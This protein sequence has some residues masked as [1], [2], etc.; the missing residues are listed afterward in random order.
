MGIPVA[1]LSQSQNYIVFIN[2]SIIAQFYWC[3]IM[4]SLISV[5]N[6]TV[7]QCSILVQFAVFWN[8]QFISVPYWVHFAAQFVNVLYW[9]SLSVFMKVFL[10]AQFNIVC[11]Y[12]HICTCVPEC[13]CNHTVY[14]CL[15][16][17][18]WSH[19]SSQLIRS[20]SQSVSVLIIP[21]LK[22]SV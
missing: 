7:Y 21:S 14:H 11:V 13:D 16:M 15:Q 12:I 5:G 1:L 17:C 10:G 2:V 4:A 6:C 22:T 20:V 19:H 3:P 9:Y 18:P 8:A